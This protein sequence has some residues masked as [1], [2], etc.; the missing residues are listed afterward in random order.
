MPLASLLADLSSSVNNMVS[1]S[2][3][4]LTAH[5]CFKY[6]S[7]FCY[8]WDEVQTAWRG[9]KALQHPICP[10]AFH[11]QCCGP[12]PARPNRFT[13]FLP[14][15]CLR[16]CCVLC[17]K[18]FPCSPGAIL[19][20]YEIQQKGSPFRGRRLPPSLLEMKCSFFWISS[21]CLFLLLLR[22]LT[23]LLSLFAF[24]K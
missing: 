17:S 23:T 3:N 11:P 1:L 10:T 12:V 21:R 16:T 22:C 15:L 19:V 4:Q 8:L 24:L 6:F 14:Y 18:G 13:L 20:T 5:P 7:S 2:W 9:D